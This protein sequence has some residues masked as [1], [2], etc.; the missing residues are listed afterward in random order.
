M[1][2]IRTHN[3]KTI[4]VEHSVVTPRPYDRMFQIQGT[5]GFANKY[6]NEGLALGGKDLTGIDSEDLDAEDY[7]SDAERDILMEAY[8]HPILKQYEAKAREVGGH[9]GMDF[10]MDSRLIYCLKNGLPLDQDVYDAAEWSCLV[11]LTEVSINHG[12]MPVVIP[13]FTRGEWNKLD[14]LKLYY[15]N[16]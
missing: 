10:I 15:A 11:E 4:L 14:G 13:D 16:K 1:T 8:K 3:G 5:R 2:F 12:N 6:P 9:G 7:M